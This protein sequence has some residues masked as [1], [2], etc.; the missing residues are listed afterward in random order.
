M[1]GYDRAAGRPN[2]FEVDLAAIAHNVAVLR[3]ALPP[4][5]RICAAVKANAYGFGLL[6]AARTLADAGVDL[7]GLVDLRDAARLRA[8]GISCPILLYGGT[9]LDAA[10]LLQVTEY[11][12]I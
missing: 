11:E 3:A 10:A 12:L 8:D 9:V 4:G 6:P 2:T 7:L 1:A 5:T